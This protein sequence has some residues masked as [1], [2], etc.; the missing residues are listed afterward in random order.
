MK[1]PLNKRKK[2]RHWSFSFDKLGRVTYY[3]TYEDLTGH[4]I[5]KEDFPATANDRLVGAVEAP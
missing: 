3:V 1:K 4:R 2:V 5:P